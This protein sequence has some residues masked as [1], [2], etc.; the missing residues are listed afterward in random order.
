MLRLDREWG[1]DRCKRHGVRLSIAIDVDFDNRAR[2][3]QVVV[4]LAGK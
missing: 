3:R 1:P 2:K 4:Q